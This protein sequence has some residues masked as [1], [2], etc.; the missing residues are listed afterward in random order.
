[1][2]SGENRLEAGEKYRRAKRIWEFNFTGTTAVHFGYKHAS[3]EEKQEIEER[4][5]R[6]A[7]AMSI[8]QRALGDM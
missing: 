7:I 4:R 2:D 3:A 1:M 8:M 5:H 6:A